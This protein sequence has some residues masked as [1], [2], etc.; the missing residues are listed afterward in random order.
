[1]KPRIETLTKKKLIGKRMVMSFADNKTRQLWQSFMPRRHE[2]Q[3][4]IG[5]ERY[6]L[7]VYPPSYFDNFNPST[8]FEKWAAIEVADFDVVPDG[9]ETFTLPGGL[10][11]VFLY[12]GASKD[13]R[14]TFQ[15]IFGTWLPNS[16]YSLDNRPH[17]EVLG[18]KYKNDDPASEEDIWIPI[19]FR[20]F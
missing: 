5:I 6:S 17:F 3:N 18:E 19:R 11:A 9:M 4:N 12:K 15:H 16:E 13:A 14:A 8:R 2:I 7:Q 10:Y 20:V 1:M